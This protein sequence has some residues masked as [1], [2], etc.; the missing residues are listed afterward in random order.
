MLKTNETF[1]DK[2]EELES[3]LEHASDLNDELQE[4]VQYRRHI[5]E[6]SERIDNLARSI[7]DLKIMVEEKLHN[8]IVV[9][10]KGK[11]K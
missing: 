8:L 9:V 11:S 6:M 7:E 2:M 10:S 1:T 4:S 3:A 5:L